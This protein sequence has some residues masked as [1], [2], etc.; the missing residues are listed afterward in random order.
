MSDLQRVG[1]V[2]G[3]TGTAPPFTADNTGA[4]RVT[5]AHSR[6]C[7]ATERGTVFSD[8]LAVVTAIVAATFNISTLTATCTPIAGLWNP[9]TSG[10]NAILLS[11]TLNTIKTSLTNTGG[12]PLF[13]ATSAGQLALTLGNVPLNRKTLVKAGSACKGL[14]NIALTGL[15]GSLVVNGASAVFGGA[16]GLV[17][18]VES[19]TGTAVINAAARE[20][21]DGEWIIPP[22]GVIALLWGSAPVAVSGAS[23]LVWE[24]KAILP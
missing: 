4:Q 1:A 11:A 23:M 10:V 24:E 18:F 20:L 21:F 6:Y 16:S 8:G 5:D 19:A 13:W 9:P 14:C 12:G 17:S 7:D 15:V 3:G 22:G 2:M